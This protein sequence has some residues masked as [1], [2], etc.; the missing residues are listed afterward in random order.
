MAGKGAWSPLILLGALTDLYWEKEVL[1]ILCVLP[2]FKS[3]PGWPL[4]SLL[5]LQI[6]HW[7]EQVNKSPFCRLPLSFTLRD[8]SSLKRE[9]H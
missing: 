6:R 2:A 5:C 9:P 8:I 1:G 7:L 4:H 3:L